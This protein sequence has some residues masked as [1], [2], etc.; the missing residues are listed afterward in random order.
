MA[1]LK[2]IFMLISSITKQPRHK[3]NPTFLYAGLLFFIR[4]GASDDSDSIILIWE[5]AGI[6]GG[7][8]P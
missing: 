1:Y 8:H 7:F 3:E 5:Y 2:R 6:R 4:T